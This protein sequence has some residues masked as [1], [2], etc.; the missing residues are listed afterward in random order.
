MDWSKIDWAVVAATLIGPAVAVGITLWYQNRDRAYQIK[1][2]VFT[3]MMRLRRH[4]LSGEYVGALN[5]V[6]VV[7]HNAPTVVTR[8]KELMSIL[9][10][11][12]WKTGDDAVHRLVGN[13]EAKATELLSEMAKAL[14]IQL[15]QMDI[16]RGAYAPEGWANEEELSKAIRTAAVKVLQGAQPIAVQVRQ[17]SDLPQTQAPNDLGWDKLAKALFE[18]EI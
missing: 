15:E 6:P 11:P 14:S 17:A 12:S 2:T 7:F 1:L 18:K 10:D 4:Q 16:H 5:L 3:T 8:Y 13:T 9:S